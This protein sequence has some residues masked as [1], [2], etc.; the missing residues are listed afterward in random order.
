MEMIECRADEFELG[1]QILQP[2]FPF[3]FSAIVC[4][5]IQSPGVFPPP[6]QLKSTLGLDYT[7]ARKSGATGDFV[8]SIYEL[9]G[10]DSY[11]TLSEVP[12]TPATVANCVVFILVDLSRP[13][14]VMDQARLWLHNV[15]ERVAA[16]TAG[17]QKT[18]QAAAIGIAKRAVEQSKGGSQW[19]G[20]PLVLV[21]T[22]YDAFRQHDPP[23]RT[24]DPSPRSSRCLR[25]GC[26]APAAEPPLPCRLTPAAEP[27][28]ARGPAEFPAVAVGRALLVVAVGPAERLHGAAAAGPPAPRDLATA[29]ALGWMRTLVLQAPLRHPL[30]PVLDPAAPLHVP[31][32]ADSMPALEPPGQAGR[33]SS[34]DALFQ[35]WRDQVQAAFPGADPAWPSPPI[36]DGSFQAQL[37]RFGEPLID[38]RLADLQIECP[39]PSHSPMAGAVGPAGSPSPSPSPASGRAPSRRRP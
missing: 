15:T 29:K 14:T 18:N 31:A 23:S 20:I 28:Q 24:G 35:Y 1:L 19:C 27:P 34:P 30:A 37:G 16:A 25:P 8:V 12:I 5:I 9:G 10:G 39:I 21:A 13:R 33:G 11:L 26:L 17:L 3:L 2:G 36:D 38:S 6:N 7:F 4:S 32:G 22:H